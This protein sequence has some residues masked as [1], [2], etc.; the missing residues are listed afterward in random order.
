MRSV[1]RNKQVVVE[2]GKYFFKEEHVYAP[3]DPNGNLA[4]AAMAGDITQQELDEYTK[5][6]MIFT[7]H[8]ELHDIHKEVKSKKDRVDEIK[9]MLQGLGV[10]PNNILTKPIPPRP[11]PPKPKKNKPVDSIT[12]T[13][14][15]PTTPTTPDTNP[16]KPNKPV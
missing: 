11:V 15:D 13:P 8:Q 6:Q 5:N 3:H 14:V 9:S 12:P 1:G 16:N 7:L 2:N 4:S 10:D